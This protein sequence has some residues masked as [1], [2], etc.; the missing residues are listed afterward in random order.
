MLASRHSLAQAAGPPPVNLLFIITDQQRWDA[1][2]CAGNRV[3]RTPNLDRLA[4]DGV[5][6]ERAYSHCPVCVP[7][8]ASILTGHSIDST[9]VVSNREADDAALPAEAGIRS[10]PTFDELLD[11]RGYYAEYHGKWHNPLLHT[12]VYD[13]HVEMNNDAGMGRRYT[14]F[15]RE[16]LGQRAPQPGEQIGWGGQPYRMDPIDARY[17]LPPG[18][19]PATPDGT[20]R[21]PSQ[22]D[23]QGCLDIPPE[24]TST[25]LQAQSTIAAI[26]RAGDRPFTIT[27]SFH[28]PHSPFVLPKPYHGMYPP[29]DLE[30][31]A[32]IDDP[33]ANSP[34]PAA[35]GRQGLPA[36]RDPAKIGYFISNYYGLIAEIDDWVGRILDTLRETGNDRRT[37]V[38]FTSD[39]GELLGS[40]GM[41]EKNVF[42]EESVHIPLLMRLPGIIPSGRVVTE[43]VSH[44]DLFPTILDYTQT[45]ARPSEGTSLRA[46]IEGQREPDRAV[47]AEWPSE[48]VPGFMVCT[49]EWKLL[50]G[51]TAAASSLDALY[52]L[53]TD[54]HELDNLIGRNPDREQHQAQAEAMKARLVSWLERVDSPYLDEVR[55]RPVIDPNILPPRA[56]EL[57]VVLA[58]PPVQR[59]IAFTTRNAVT[60]NTPVTVAGRQGWRTERVDGKENLRYVY[61]RVA[62]DEF[63]NDGAPACEISLDYLD[64]GDVS[65]RLVYDSSDP[66]VRVVPHAPG[67]WKPA[68]TVEFGHTGQ[69]QTASFTVTDARF[70]QRCNG[71]DLR[72]EVQGDVDIVLGGLRIRRTAAP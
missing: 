23:D 19:Q 32:S 13:N 61:F 12:Q 42:Y 35:N 68:G 30:P 60:A 59:G 63:C 25:A 17:G 66:A 44:L 69:W 14:E 53:T 33:M 16:K 34:Y 8:R 21:K 1:L 6:F 71:H 57:S 41:R 65:V 49:H 45:P 70:A 27:C 11:Q 24:Y 50:F 43:P 51:R 26:H 37:L 46:L 48:T 39:H 20:P 52:H 62:Y 29:A 54:P 67:A 64:E 36:Y 9:G 7:A 56:T 10:L 3:L 15:L 4:A 47:V 38:I 55:Q 22:P 5:R 18:A 28:F 58:D 72:V 2:S 40:H 31:P